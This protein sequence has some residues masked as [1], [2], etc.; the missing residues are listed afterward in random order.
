MPSGT[1]Y[2]AVVIGSGPNG[3][4][5]AITIAQAGYSVVVLEAKDTIGGG[6]RSA[7]LT[8]PG[9]VHD[10]CSA[11]HPMG[12]SSRFFSS[13][14]L[15]EH[16]LRW[17]EPPAPLAHPL[18]DGSA[19]IVERSIERTARG[20]GADE[21]AYTD[22]MQ[23]LVADWDW[24]SQALATPTA[25]MWHPLSA[26]RFGWHA[27]Q[28]AS[29]LARSLFRENRARAVF[30]GHAAHSLLPLERLP[31]GAFGLML[32][33][34]THAAGWPFAAGGSQSIANAL[35]SY[36]KS[37]GG[38]IVT[39]NLIQ[40]FKQLPPAR[41]YLFDVTPRQLLE[42]AAE[43]FSPGFRN[44]LAGYG[45]G[46]GVCKIDWALADIIPW[47]AKNCSRAGTVHIGGSLE[48]IEASE[49]APWQNQHAAKP[50]VLLAQPTFFDSSRAPAGRQIA[51][52]YCHVP[53]A[54]SVDMTEQ[55]ENQI[56]RFA[57]GFRKIVLKR[58][59]AVASSLSSGNAN[60]VGGDI[61]GGASDLRQFF[62]RPTRRLYRTT[63]KN[64][65]LCSSSTP[66][67]A[68]VH[69]LCGYRAGQA[70]LQ[71]LREARLRN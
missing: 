20:L 39:S 31:S 18:D 67:G 26:A 35:A 40:S 6:T 64:I 27:M 17:I 21:K 47:T 43:Q 41:V 4:A 53:N 30:A 7:E 58:H 71:L 59:I 70:A 69:G 33:V 56:E 12:V 34:T 1:S 19:V 51:W 8:L 23:A 66:P 16:G 44:Q 60:L 55:I 24:L 62:F 10:V 37:L 61:G 25:A 45:Y 42:I 22:L 52:A 15:A 63:Q 46:P 28:S 13:L 68:G 29:R 11:V 38:E 65:F 14:P 54:S 36:L 50:F 2:D 48:E 9:F 3:L 57:P 49:R 32:G 5:A